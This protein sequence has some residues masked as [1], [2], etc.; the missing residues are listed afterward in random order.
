M[1]EPL[2][3]P[4]GTR[5]SASGLLV[6]IHT[7]EGLVGARRGAGPATTSQMQANPKTSIGTQCGGGRYRVTYVSTDVYIVSCRATS[8]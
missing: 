5:H 4:G 1:R 2:V 8:E 7:D 3:W 6:Q